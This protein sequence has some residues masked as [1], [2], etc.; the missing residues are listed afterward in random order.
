MPNHCN[1]IITVSGPI[2]ELRRFLSEVASEKSVFD[3]N[4]ILPCPKE[5]LDV[6]SPVR[7][8]TQEEILQM[9]EKHRQLNKG[10]H[11]SL[12]RPHGLGITKE[13][14]S[15]LI[16]RFGYDNWY[17]WCCENWGTKWGAYDVTD[18]VKVGKGFEASY[19]S[20]WAP[21]TNGLVN[22]SKLFPSLSFRNCYMET[23]MDFCGYDVIEN[24]EIIEAD[25]DKISSD[26]GLKFCEER[27]G[28]EPYVDEEESIPV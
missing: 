18:W 5:L 25:E 15:E 28:Y 8:M 1:N 11:S 26:T 20:A 7:I 24:G 23:G 10:E 2:K 14:Q 9:W 22:L 4:K 3:F 13:R 19:D 16:A 12:T 27:F 17:D 21:P 6:A